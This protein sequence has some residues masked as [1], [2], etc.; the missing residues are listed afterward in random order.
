MY[1]FIYIYISILSNDKFFF[2]LVSL[3]R[4]YIYTSKL[5]CIKYK[6]HFQAVY[7]Y[8]LLL[9]KKPINLITSSANAIRG[10]GS[11]GVGAGGKRQYNNEIYIVYFTY[12]YW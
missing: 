6:S 7:F 10:L 5:Q 2:M 8:I 1:N 12:T 11:L 4:P 3:V 9:E